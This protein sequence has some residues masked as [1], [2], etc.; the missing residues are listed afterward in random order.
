[1]KY[2]SFSANNDSMQALVNKKM[3]VVMVWYL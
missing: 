2:P 3:G 1:M